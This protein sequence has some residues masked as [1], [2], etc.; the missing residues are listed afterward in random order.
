M[1]FVDFSLF[2]LVDFLNY[3]SDGQTFEKHANLKSFHETIANLPRFR[4][5]WADYAKLIKQPFKFGQMTAI[6]M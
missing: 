3:F 2:E 4:D 1:T 5:A 6:T